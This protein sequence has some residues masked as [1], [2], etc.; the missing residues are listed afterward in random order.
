MSAPP[1]R[2]RPSIT[3]RTS[4][5]SSWSAGSGG[6]ISTRP[7]AAWIARTYERA[8]RKASWSH[9]LQRA[10][11][12]AVQMPMT[13]RATR[14]EA[15]RWPDPLTRAVRRA[16]VRSPCGV[17][18][19]GR[20]DRCRVDPARAQDPP[21]GAVALARDAEEDVLG[22]D[23]G[24]AHRDRLAQRE[25]EDLLR[26]RRERE[27]PGGGA[28][29]AAAAGQRAR[30][31]RP[32]DP[33]AHRVEV[34]AQG[35]ER[36]GVDPRLA[37]ADDALDLAARPLAVDGEALAQQARRAAVGVVEQAEQQVLGADPP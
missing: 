2:M 34:D 29:P 24:V 25:L 32:L 18:L 12:T 14:T 31:E 16:G 33:L 35:G 27:L 21:A 4:S 36:V 28:A 6:I 7:P 10:R 37:A 13:G 30:A 9:T 17:A 8:R 11:S 5:G 3:S 1:A 15:T 20:A 23:A 19:Q 26:A 22:A